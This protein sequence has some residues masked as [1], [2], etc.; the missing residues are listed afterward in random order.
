MNYE[1]FPELE[2]STSTILNCLL[3]AGLE[4]E[5]GT[6]WQLSVSHFTDIELWCQS[7]FNNINMR[8]FDTGTLNQEQSLHTQKLFWQSYWYLKP[9]RTIQKT[10][11]LKDYSTRL[12]SVGRDDDVNQVWREH[13]ECQRRDK[14]KVSDHSSRVLV[15]EEQSLIITT[16]T[17]FLISEML[18]M[19][20]K[21][22]ESSWDHQLTFLTA[23]I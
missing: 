4:S 8:Y 19:I 13:G 11:V 6:F 21:W 1:S 3:E 16:L 2:I 22:P 14:F 5:V 17:L 18:R 7:T 15:S 9:D 20:L 23:L 10:A 12:V